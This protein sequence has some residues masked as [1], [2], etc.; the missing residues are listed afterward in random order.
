MIRLQ[1]VR[2][3]PISERH[4]P[5]RGSGS[6]KPHSS[7]AVKGRLRRRRAGKQGPVKMS[8]VRVRIPEGPELVACGLRGMLESHNDRIEIVDPGEPTVDVEVLEAGTGSDRSGA[9]ARL[10]RDGGRR[11]VV[12]VDDSASPR[13]VRRALGLGAAGLLVASEPADVLADALV[14]AAE[15]AVVLSR[16]LEPSVAHGAPRW[17]GEDRGL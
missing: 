5:H 6:S 1:R 10:G 4:E 3:L 17:P 15:G 16:S 12:L 11:Q 13:L 14:R 9:L 2:W 8:R 7:R